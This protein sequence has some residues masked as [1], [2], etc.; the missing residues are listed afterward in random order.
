MSTTDQLTTAQL[1]SLA[2]DAESAR[3]YLKAAELYESAL[4]VYP[5]HHVGSV[6]HRDDKAALAARAFSCRGMARNAA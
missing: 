4:A 3:D 2:Y 1:R 6:M 5:S